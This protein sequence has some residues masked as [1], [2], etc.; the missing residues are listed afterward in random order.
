M[1]T[2]LYFLHTD[3]KSELTGRERFCDEPHRLFD[4][5]LFAADCGAACYL[6]IKNG[7]RLRD[8][9]RKN[10]FLSEGA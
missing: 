1:Q 10:T 7:C 2:V 3:T 8:D 6:K 9:I 4:E 5:P